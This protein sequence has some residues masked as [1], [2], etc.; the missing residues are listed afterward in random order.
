[1]IKSDISILGAAL[2]II[3]L[4]LSVAVYA[5]IDRREMLRTMHSE[6]VKRCVSAGSKKQSTA[7]SREN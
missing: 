2:I 5:L 6:Y 3:L 7:F 1:M 4:F